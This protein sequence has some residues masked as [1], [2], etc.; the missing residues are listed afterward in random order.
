MKS[1]L[2]KQIS[3]L[4]L[5]ALLLI[6]GVGGAAW[7]KFSLVITNQHEIANITS[8]LRNQIEADM[9]HDA[10]RAD[11]IS[12]ILAG[13]SNNDI[14]AKDAAKSL[15]EHAKLFREHVA[16]NAAMKFGNKVTESIS[17][18]AKPLED[19]IA[20]AERVVSLASKD[21]PGAEAQLPAFQDAFTKLEGEMSKLSDAIEEESKVKASE[22]ESLVASFKSILLTSLAV[23][24]TLLVFLTLFL[25]RI[26]P[27]PFRKIVHELS[28][29]A[30]AANSTA[31]NVA[32]TSQDLAAGASESA[33]S[34]EETS[35]SLEEVSSMIKRTSD[36]AQSARQLAGEARAAADHGATD[37]QYMSKA[38]A[39]I[40]ASSDNIAKIIKT[41]DEIAFQTNL[42]ALNAA[43]EAARAGEAGAGFAVVADEVRS[44]AQR[45][46]LAAK[47]TAAKIEDSIQKSNRGVQISDKVNVGLNEIVTRT[48]Q[49]DEL[50]NEIA[51]ATSE[52]SQ[53][54]IQINAAIGQFDHV[55]QNTAANS[56]TIAHAAQQ[57]R[58]QA[59]SLDTGINDL[60]ELVGGEKA[61]LKKSA[62][63]TQPATKPTPAPT[64]KSFRPKSNIPTANRDRANAAISLST[65]PS[66]SKANEPIP[67]GFTDF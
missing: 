28:N 62:D 6:A 4:T 58:L 66:T 37:M 36:N 45:S 57:L 29:T 3:I 32:A 2:I 24:A 52:Q 64:Q 33:A 48:R 60:Q 42:L 44:L 11:V 12:R 47:E 51:S 39:E 54:I 16:T 61:D 5:T 65:I 67:A 15:E 19:Y 40:K 13:K 41:I 18:I 56:N 63:P 8:G 31:A 25:A 59:S 7:T 30:A 22:N 35:A 21:L 53:G 9:M 10:L 49:M 14:A 55:T 20:A 50:I 17:R 27:R 26:I 1:S 43:V 23:A 34:L 38:M 46:A